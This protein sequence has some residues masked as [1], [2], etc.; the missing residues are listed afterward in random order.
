MVNLIH[1]PCRVAGLYRWAA[2]RGLVRRGSIDEGFV[3]HKLLSESFGKGALQPFRLFAA[4]GRSLGELYAYSGS[5]GRELRSLAAVVASPS[6]SDF[7]QITDLRSKPMPVEFQSG[8]VLG[9]DV[10]VR[11]T[12]RSKRAMGRN[13]ESGQR[14]FDKSREVDAYLLAQLRHKMPGGSNLSQTNPGVTRQ[15]VYREWLQQK[16]GN[17]CILDEFVLRKFQRT[18]S[19]RGRN[20]LVE[21][22]DITVHGTITVRDSGLFAELLRKGIGRHKAF[23]YGMV[24][25]RPPGVTTD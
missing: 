9:F 2:R 3:L 17:A 21:G 14:V 19:V 25:L 23:G 16:L 5:T 24:L 1:L 22:P 20:V 8:T 10:R 11:P 15:E 18:L 4:R 12:R 7:A 6:L 13:P